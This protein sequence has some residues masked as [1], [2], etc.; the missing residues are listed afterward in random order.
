MVLRR[1]RGSHHI[2][3][4]DLGLTTILPSHLEHWGQRA[5]PHTQPLPVRWMEGSMAQTE[6][7]VRV[8]EPQFPALD[9]I[10]TTSCLGVADKRRPH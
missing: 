5:C 4:V 10:R 7:T 2:A 3:R 1:S 6:S 8:S 9:V